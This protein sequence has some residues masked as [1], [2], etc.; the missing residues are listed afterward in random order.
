MLHL[1]D[2]RCEYLENPLG[3]DVHDPRLSWVARGSG[4]GERQSAYQVIAATA[5]EKLSLGKADLWDSGKVISDDTQVPYNGRLLGSMEG[6]WWRVKAWDRN[7]DP[8]E[9]S[10]PAYFEMGLLQPDDW[11]AEWIGFPGIWPGRAVYYRCDFELVDKVKRARVY[12]AGLGWSELRIN[13]QRVNDRVLDP[14]QTDYARRILYTTDAV[15][16]HL[17]PGNN[18]IGVIL[19]N[20]WLGG[21]RLLLQLYLEMPDG[22]SAV[23]T[24]NISREHTWLIS[25]GPIREN[26][27]F[28][29]SDHR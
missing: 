29:G 15:E 17:H 22:K 27:V 14:A 16:N 11:K 7:G 18:T 21:T 4:R 2:L 25:D 9:F 23:V 1:T 28:H 3:I 6:C 12:M 10:A 5:R 24:S 26:S 8:G 19:G 20:G 13:G